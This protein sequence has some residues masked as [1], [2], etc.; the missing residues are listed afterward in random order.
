MARLM[1][2]QYPTAEE[3]A[4]IRRQQDGQEE[5]EDIKKEPAKDR[6]ALS[7]CLGG[8]M[9]VQFPKFVM[10]NNSRI[11]IL[12]FTLVVLLILFILWYFLVNSQ[13][14]IQKMPHMQVH[15]CGQDGRLCQPS[16]PDMQNVFQKWH[17]SHLCT[18]STSYEYWRNPY[19]KYK[20]LGC[21]PMCGQMDLDKGLN[22][23]KD[24]QIGCIMPSDTINVQPTMA[25]VPTYI[26]E[27][28]FT[29]ATG[30]PMTCPKGYFTQAH[31]GVCSYS[32]QHFVPGAD[33]ITVAFSHEFVVSPEIGAFVFG[34]EDKRANQLSGNADGWGQ[35]MET[36]FFSHNGNEVATYNN[37]NFI[38]PTI[39][40]LLA[41]ADYD[42]VGPSGNLNLD[43][44]YSRRE[45]N[46]PKSM[47]GKKMPD[48]SL[49]MTGVTLTIDLAIT[50]T[51]KCRHLKL[52]EDKTVSTGRPVACMFTHAERQWTSVDET[53][54]IGMDGTYKTVKKQG[55]R[56]KFRLR[57]NIQLF[58]LQTIMQNI[59]VAIVWIQIPLLLV[60]W[61]TTFC[62]G[63][64]SSVYSRVIHQDVS[65]G[66]ACKGL[67]A[68]LVSHSAAYMDLQDKPDGITKARLLER[69]QNILKNN[70]N[71]DDEEVKKYADFV[72]EG[73]QSMGEGEIVINET[74]N[75]QEFCTACCT[76]EP[77]KFE[78]MVTLF[79]KDRKTGCLERCFLDDTIRA[80][81][82]AA[83]MEADERGPE[84]V[85]E[86]DTK[87]AELMKSLLEV[88]TCSDQVEELEDLVDKCQKMCVT[89]RDENYEM[90][91]KA[92]PIATERRAL[93][94]GVIDPIADFTPTEDPKPDQRESVCSIADEEDPGRG[95]AEQVEQA[96][97]EKEIT[98]D[99]EV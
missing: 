95:P 76:D 58:D 37:K 38:N 1:S 31:T 81:I 77:L 24:E 55:V 20:P 19:D 36:V 59:T 97:P 30:S 40:Q 16:L 63:H 54:S 90:H 9:S 33:N 74:I 53:V 41:A 48:A 17:K 92:L 32:H 27:T 86:S 22:V 78:S 70:E 88:Q 45:H 35:G 73:F 5:E 75:I 94:K 3:R 84:P 87:Q 43:Q 62:L 72:F 67:A 18:K 50:D 13:Y 68:R 29:P 44:R 15:L 60:Y 34:M 65:L 47:K 56:I 85:E 49:R 82:R 64:L 8:F 6:S 23:A 21:M 42:D 66:D 57:G 39:E 14:N 79:D 4:A 11:T 51:G 12:Y 69:I 96:E 28:I 80:V 61:F 98:E 7:R 99:D 91:V 10:I 83:K 52:D 25:F 89:E 71:I 93:G 26:E 46:V 2:S